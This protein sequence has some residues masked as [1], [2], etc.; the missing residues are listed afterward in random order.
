ME[1]QNRSGFRFKDH[2]TDASL[3]W[4]NLGTYNKDREIYTLNDKYIR[5]FI[6]KS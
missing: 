3:G 6:R 1:M 4:K 5:D 2:L